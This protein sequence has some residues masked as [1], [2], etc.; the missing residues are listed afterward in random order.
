VKEGLGLGRA[1]QADSALLAEALAEERLPSLSDL[2]AGTTPSSQRA[3]AEDEAAVLGHYIQQRY[4][5]EGLI[6]LLH[7][8]RRAP[9]LDTLLVTAFGT[10]LSTFE[11]RWLNYLQEELN[12][13]AFGPFERT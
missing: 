1:Y 12:P 10:D 8:M 7:A 13:A 2:W 4:G 6:L 5:R 3:I 11:Q 9:S